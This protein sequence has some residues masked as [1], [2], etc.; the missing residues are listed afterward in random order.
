MSQVRKL[1]QGNKIPKAQDGYKFKLDSQDVYFTDE[2]LAEIDKKISAL[3]MDYRRFL[4]NATTAIKSGNESGNRA[5]NTVTINQLS[6]LGKGDMRRLEKKSGTYL[7]AIFKPDSYSAKEAINEYLNILYS[8]ANK[9][10]SKDK[11]DK[12]VIPL[13]FNKNENGTY[14]LSTT[15]GENYNAKARILDVLASNG[16]GKDYKYDMSDWNLGWLPGWMSSLPGEDKAKAAQDY[17]NDLWTRMASGYDPKLTPDDE[18][19]LNNFYINFGFK[20]PKKT[21]DSSNGSEGSASDE[22][23]IPGIIYTKDGEIDPD[24]REENG[25][26]RTYRDKNGNLRAIS[27][28]GDNKPYLLGS[29]ERLMKYGLSDDYLD[30]V[31]YKGRIYKPSE[32]TPE[33]N[34][35]LY[36]KMQAVITKNNSV[37]NPNDLAEALSEIIDYTDYNV[38]NYGYYNPEESF[39]NQAAIRREL[40]MTGNYGVFDATPAYESPEGTQIFGLY[41]YNTPGTEQWGF[42][43]PFYLIVNPDG[44]LKSVSG[45][46]LNNHRFETIPE[47]YAQIPNTEY[48]AAPSFS[49]WAVKTG[50][51]AALT[52]RVPAAEA[53]RGYYNIYETWAGD[54]YY[55]NSGKGVVRI[56]EELKQQI[57]RGYR[58]KPKEMETGRYFGNTTSS[59][60]SASTNNDIQY[61]GFGR[62][63]ILKEGGLVKVKPLPFKYQK[64]SPLLTKA[65]S[66][67]IQT[68][69]N[70]HDPLSSS[71]KLS[72]TDG[73]SLQNFWD[74]LST[75]EKEEIVA[76][77]IDLGGAVAGLIPGGSTVGA[78]TGLGS[79]ALFLDA[80]KKRKGH[81][82]AEDWGQA[83]LSTL[84]DVVSLIPYAGEVGKDIKI[85]MGLKKIA[86]PL[87][88][89]FT[90]AGLYEAATVISKPKDEWTTDDLIKLSSGLQAITNIGVGMRVGRGESRLAARL[91]ADAKPEVP[92]YRSKKEYTITTEKTEAYGKKGKKTRVVSEESKT[93]I[94]LDE[95]DVRAVIE[96][97]KKAGNTLREILQDKYK[98]KKSDISSDDKALLEEFGFTA[99]EKR[100]FGLFGKKSVTAEA[101]ETKEPEKFSKYGYLLDPINFRNPEGKRR[102]YI[103]RQLASTPDITTR[104]SASGVRPIQST[105]HETIYSGNV[106]NSKAERRAY[107]AS[108]VRRGAM[109]NDTWYLKTPIDE[110]IGEKTFVQ[111][112]DLDAANTAAELDTKYNFSGEQPRLHQEIPGEFKKSDLIYS[113]RAATKPEN[114]PKASPS[115]RLGAESVPNKELV[116]YVLGSGEEKGLGTREAIEFLNGLTDKKRKSLLSA[117]RNSGDQ[118]GLEIANHFT[119]TGS[120]KTT[121]DKLHKGKEGISK[122]VEQLKERGKNSGGRRERQLKEMAA[123]LEELRNSK[124]PMKTLSKLGKNEKGKALANENATEYREAL[125]Q[126]LRD[127]VYSKLSGLRLDR[128]LIKTKNQMRKD[129]LMFKRGGVLKFEKGSIGGWLKKTGTW[130]DKAPL[131]AELADLWVNNHYNDKAFDALRRGAEATEVHKQPYQVVTAPTDN[132]AYERQLQNIRNERMSN[133]QASTSDTVLNDALK[134]QK[135]AKLYERENTV[136]SSINQNNAVGQARDAEARTIQNQI[137]STVANDWL[138]SKAASNSAA[139]QI[140]G[141]RQLL[142]GKNISNLLMWIKRGIASDKEKLDTAGEFA[143]SQAQL[144]AK[145]D[146]F[147]TNFPDAYTEYNTLP[148]EEKLKYTDIADFIQIKYPQDWLKYK[149]DYDKLENDQIK[150]TYDFKVRPTLLP[151]VSPTFSTIA[152]QKKGGRLRGNTRYKNEPDEQVWIDSNKAVHAAVAKLQ[153]NTIKLLLRALK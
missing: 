37:K 20:D 28:E 63:S 87:G 150:E 65:P 38:G 101:I 36:N 120:Q 111:K 149:E 144:K 128:Y 8:V 46:N 93:P 11:L 85:G 90:L 133:E 97:D 4:G 39:W 151:N 109:P 75:A 49:D 34:I 68:P 135:D 73:S 124:D 5:E 81:I 96:S 137:D 102:A 91:S 13:I 142:R 134:N 30:S 7:E 12:T 57:L 131:V 33:T 114:K 15:A 69:T 2:D 141:Q 1:L 83:A 110:G 59:N 152:T 89:L 113:A 55:N 107:V 62:S 138:A 92:V 147:V 18:N 24:Q 29:K 58:P 78:V 74:S 67:R 61:R 122:A 106:F 21:V 71:V 99:N 82:E 47:E 72:S 23:K 66:E 32:I 119:E 54:W 115:A 31:L 86:A 129:G 53:S 16:A 105:S 136:M 88:K 22:D 77:S 3:P 6:N 19:F 84:L 79:T 116:S 56:S 118:R 43:R 103:D 145:H 148:P 76:T 130:Y 14:N 45:T 27:R 52:M 108:L 48:G 41:D 132:S 146:F 117:L 95:D 121:K 140:E 42:R 94:T 123:N 143:L 104:F 26:F 9:T 51:R 139:E 50:Q 17:V 127:A 153:D 80:A 60:N 40:G 25:A 35:D 64:G 125:N 44:T 126:A 100:R 112:H 70:L 98:V 10:R